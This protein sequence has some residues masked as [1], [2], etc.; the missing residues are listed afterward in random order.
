[1]I[2]ISVF[3]KATEIPKTMTLTHLFWQVL[4]PSFQP[5]QWL[6]VTFLSSFILFKSFPIFHGFPFAFSM[7]FW[8]HPNGMLSI[9][10][11]S[12]HLSYSETL[13][14][15]ALSGLSSLSSA[16]LTFMRAVQKVSSHVIWE[17]ETFIEGGTRYK[18][19]CTQDND[20]AVP[21]KV[22][23]LG[24]PQFSQSPSAAT[25]YF[26]KSH[27][28]SEISSLWKVILVLGKARSH[29]A[30]NLGYKGAESPGW[31]MMHKQ[32][33]FPMKLPITRCP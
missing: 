23:I 22:G 30:P 10:G 33:H 29:R 11:P 7:A 13:P 12:D 15:S 2:I 28:W 5:T 27:Q 1:M 14:H 20:A 32:V 3:F 4:H 31:D 9:G 24:P 17:I 25:S 21:F 6:I 8:S 26:P 16:M 18:K 19:H